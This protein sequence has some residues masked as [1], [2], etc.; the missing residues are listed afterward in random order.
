[1]FNYTVWT[2][3]NPTPHH[4]TLDSRDL[5]DTFERWLKTEKLTYAKGYVVPVEGGTVALNFANVAKMDV[6]PV[7]DGPKVWPVH[8]A[9]TVIRP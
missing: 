6:S 8:D 3:G 7:E 9:P 1:M 4:F 2:V 5:F